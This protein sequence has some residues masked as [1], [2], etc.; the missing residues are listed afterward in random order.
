MAE[1]CTALATHPHLDSVTLAGCGEPTLARSLGPVIVFVKRVF[2]EYSLSVLTNGSLLTDPGAREEL[3]PA[4]RVIPTL[5]TASQKTFERIHN[6]H[7]SLTIDA[8]IRGMEEFRAQY[9]G[10]LWLE[11]FVVPGL[12]TTDEELAG[13]RSAIGRIDPDL[14]QLNTLDRPPAEGWVEAASEAEL[15]RISRVLGRQGIEIAG[16]RLTVNPAIQ[17]KTRSA[18]LVRATLHRRP[19]TVEDLVRTTGLSGAEVAKI[20]GGLERAGE[21]TSRRME[22]GV[23]YSICKK[24]EKPERM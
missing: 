9:R 22:R 20:L 23:F 15:E 12:N 4:D 19:S 5:T 10:A 2:P 17:A 6:P 11:V 7:Q 16:Q 8:I 1:L 13:L 3:L 24:P 18:D 21:I 14:V